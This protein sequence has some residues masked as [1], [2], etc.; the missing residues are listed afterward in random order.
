[1]VLEKI[2]G[3][4]A[5]CRLTDIHHIDLYGDFVFLSKTDNELSLVCAEEKIPASAAKVE[6]DWKLLRVEGALEFSMVGVIAE[7]SSILASEEIS[8]FVVSTFDTDYI[9]VKSESFHRAKTAL[10]KNGHIVK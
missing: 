7:L 4:F 8:I 6:R 3:T 9:L 5:V 10:Q 2:A 1:M